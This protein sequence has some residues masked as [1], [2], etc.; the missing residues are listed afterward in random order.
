MDVQSEWVENGLELTAKGMRTQPTSRNAIPTSQHLD[1][2]TFV[3]VLFV[4]CTC[5]G[6]QSRVSPIIPEKCL[7][8]VGQKDAD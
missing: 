7:T 1:F 3:F 4:F 5:F 2:G 6:T 8:G